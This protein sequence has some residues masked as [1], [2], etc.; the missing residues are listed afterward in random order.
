[1]IVALTLQGAVT[2]RQC[3]CQVL[4]CRTP[5]HPTHFCKY[6]GY[7]N[8]L[9]HAL[10]HVSAGP[11]TAPV[12][13]QVGG[14][15]DAPAW[16]K[17]LNYECFCLCTF[18]SRKA[19]PGLPQGLFKEA[20]DTSHQNWIFPSIPRVSG[21]SC[22][23]E[24]AQERESCCSGERGT[25]ASFPGSKLARRQLYPP[26]P[27]L[28]HQRT[29]RRCA[30]PGKFPRSVP[31]LHGHCEAS[32]SPIDLALAALKSKYSLAAAQSPGAARCGG[33]TPSGKCQHQY[34]SL[35][36]SPG[37]SSPRGAAALPGASLRSC[38]LS[39]LASLC[40]Q[41]DITRIL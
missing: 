39:P 18:L 38:S 16:K 41:R 7:I 13:W 8:L 32:S 31:S 1:M 15:L 34:E 5:P 17:P 11:R 22:L 2:E 40:S 25:F 30:L 26:S 12:E 23:A 6:E 24:Q 27:G 10:N 19:A 33:G 36:C 35:G 28:R 29:E 14:G 21:S 20:I 4:L 37:R 9:N 3:S